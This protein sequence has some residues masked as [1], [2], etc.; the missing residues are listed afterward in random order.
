MKTFSGRR[1]SQREDELLPFIA[2]LKDR[3]VRSYLEIGARHGDTF[4]A[5]MSA[6]DADAV[7]VAVDL[8]GGAWGVASS[9]DALAAACHNL[10]KGGRRAEFVLGDSG[11]PSVFESVGLYA[12][13]FGLDGWDAI[14]IDGDHRYEGVSRDWRIWGPCGRLVAFHDITGEG[15]TQRTTGDPVEVPRLWREVKALGFEFE[16]FVGPG[17]VMGIGVVYPKGLGDG[18]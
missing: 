9:K 10:R 15:V 14:L 2:R 3:G 16:E 13:E 4:H 7:G 1:P 18:R 8:P 11:S 17:S 5:V 6:L 12:A